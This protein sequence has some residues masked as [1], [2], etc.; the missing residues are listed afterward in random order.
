MFKSLSITLGTWSGQDGESWNK[1]TSTFLQVLISIQSLIL[2]E[3]PYFNE[4]GW[5]RD[6]HTTKGKTNSFNYNDNIRYRNLQWCIVDKLKNFTSG[7]ENMILS[8]F[9]F[10]KKKL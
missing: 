1:D 5:E 9:K 8:H 2:V 6:M 10:K 4:P 7:F 3:Q